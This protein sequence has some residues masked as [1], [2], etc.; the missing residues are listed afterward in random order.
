MGLTKTFSHRRA[1]SDWERALFDSVVGAFPDDPM[2][3]AE[4]AEAQKP[5]DNEIPIEDVIAWH[6]DRA[7]G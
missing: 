3:D 2:T 7:G 4:F 6:K 1:L 5:K